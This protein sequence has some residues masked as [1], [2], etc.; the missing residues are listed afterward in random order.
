[1]TCL[2]ALSLLFKITRNWVCVLFLSLLFAC[3]LTL[4]SEKETREA[5]RQE[6]RFVFQII[7][8]ILVYLFF[9]FS[10]ADLV[11]LCI[12]LIDAPSIPK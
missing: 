5:V 12:S 9:Y 1:M 7:S 4:S 8:F 2:I 11:C 3:L 10:T 6:L